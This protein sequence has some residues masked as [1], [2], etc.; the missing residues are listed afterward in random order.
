[1]DWGLVRS[2]NGLRSMINFNPIFYYFAIITD[3]LLRFT[4][5]IILIFDP[6]Q[7]PWLT[8][9]AFSTLIG[10][11]EL[12]RRWQWSIIRIENE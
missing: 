11:L 4:W 3:L 12:I 5:T 8:T 10:V 9:F 7:H 1:M 2:K 6:R